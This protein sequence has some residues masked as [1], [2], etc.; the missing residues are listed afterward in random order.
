MAAASIMFGGPLRIPKL[1]SAGKRIMFTFDY[2]V[3]R[4]RT[5][6][7][8]DPVNMPTAL[9]RIGDFSQSTVQGAPVTIYDPTTGS[10]FPGNKIPAN[11]ISATSTALLQYFPNPNLPFATRNYQTSW[12]GRN[13]SQN[14]NSRD[15]QYQDRQQ[16][17]DQRR[18]RLSGQQ[19]HSPNLFQFIDTGSGRG[20]NA[21]LA[22]SRS[23]TARV[24]NNLRYTFSRSRQLSSPYFANRENVAAELGIA[25]TSQNPANWG[26]P[27]LSFT[28]YG[29]LTDGNYSLNRNQTSAIGESL[30]W[31]RGTHNFTF[32]GDYR[33][34]Q[35][36]QLAD[37][38]GRGTYTFNG[39]MTS[40]LV[41]GVAQADTG[42]DLA[43]FLLGCPTTSSIRYGNPD[44]YFRSSGYDVFVNDDWRISPKFSL[45]FGIRWDYATPVTELYNRL[46]NLD[47]APGYTAA[48]A[49]QSGS[50]LLPGSLIHPDRNNFSPRLGFAW[51]PAQQGLA[52]GA[53]RIRRLLQH[54]GLQHHRRQ[55]GAAA[56]VRPVAQR[57]RLGG[58]PAEHQ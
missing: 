26:P 33:R 18:H 40:Y 57:L 20:I 29:G 34:Q 14:I 50:G 49:V 55:H 13:N 42:Y 28:N 25:G 4:N 37:T 48:V 58:E 15:L 31:V 52:G 53:R 11:R 38:N 24:I 2:Q 17:H 47:I 54:V 46:V 22:W 35:I 10:P 3:Q 6:T 39:S 9:E 8:S 21:N 41:N 30:T 44:K 36:N 16:G 32:G 51:R 45:N 19:Q 23:F 27:N 5:G 43:D 56:A 1:V 7:I 12:S